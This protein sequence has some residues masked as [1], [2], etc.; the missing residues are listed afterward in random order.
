MCQPCCLFFV[1]P[2]LDLYDDERRRETP[3]DDGR[4]RKMAGVDLGR[5]SVTP[6]VASSSLV[7]PAWKSRGCVDNAT[8]LVFLWTVYRRFAYAILFASR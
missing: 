8:P 4:R 7:G 1:G 6:E 5:R 2:V 3:E